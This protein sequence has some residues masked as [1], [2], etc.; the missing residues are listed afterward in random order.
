VLAGDNLVVLEVRLRV[1]IYHNNHRWM[2]QPSHWYLKAR[3]LLCLEA[4]TPYPSIHRCVPLPTQPLFCRFRVRFCVRAASLRLRSCTGGRTS[5]RRRRT[6]VT[7]VAASSTLCS[8][9]LA[10]ART[11]CSW[12]CL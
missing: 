4:L 10:S 8:V 7:R 3:A 12:R 2:R 1:D 5:A 6:V 9:L 11:S